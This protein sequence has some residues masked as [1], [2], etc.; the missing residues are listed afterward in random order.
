MNVLLRSLL[1]CCL[2]ALISTAYSQST[3]VILNVSFDTGSNGFSYQDDAFRN[4]NQAAYAA[5]N[6][7]SGIVT[8]DLGGID[9]RRINGMSGGWQTTFMLADAGD[10]TLSFDYKLSQSPHYESSEFTEMLA[11]IDGT[12]HGL[13]GQPHVDRI[14]GDG[15]NGPEITTGWQRAVIQLGSMSSGAYQ[16]TLGAYNNRK[17]ARNE[18]SHLQLDNV[19]L[20]HATGSPPP[21]PPTASAF[22]V[23]LLARP[24]GFQTVPFDMNATGEAVGYYLDFS[25]N[26]RAI[27]WDSA[28]NFVDL[29]APGTWSQAHGI[30][31]N[32][33]IAGYY[34]PTLQA[35]MPVV[36][37]QFSPVQLNVPPGHFA[38]TESVN[39]SGLAVGSS[40]PRSQRQAA[41][42]LGSDQVSP[43]GQ[44]TGAAIDVNDAGETVGRVM[45]SGFPRAAY[46]N[47]QGQLTVLGGI[48]G[49]DSNGAHAISDNGMI[50]G[51]AWDNASSRN[52]TV[53]WSSASAPPRELATFNGIFG[54]ARDINDAGW[55]VGAHSR[56]AYNGTGEALLWVGEE[57]P[58]ELNTL[59][60]ADSGWRLVEA[61]AVNNAGQ[62]FGLG[63]VSGQSGQQAFR[64]TPVSE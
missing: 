28:A 47:S 60:P 24:L 52:V 6:H 39:S 5:G 12:L 38:N 32:R 49:G 30:S 9:R 37:N 34:G 2:S 22:T 17:T 11:A 48:S 14:A 44:H 10:V 36:W 63:T 21:P 62:I 3:A 64:L 57:D 53:V 4:T 56:D 27:Y 29:A 19:L 41:F 23:E 8:V 1:V 13:N 58:V 35:T 40:G 31:N 15:N 54:V 42:W 7:S 33:L 45:V 16:L 18:S 25:L 26:Y 61:V 46:W 55:V 50:I 43:S 51:M 59:I 20:E